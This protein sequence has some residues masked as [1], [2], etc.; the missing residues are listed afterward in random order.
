MDYAANHTEI[1]RRLVEER[2]DGYPYKDL[3]CNPSNHLVD[4]ME[5]KSP[6]KKKLR[7]K[8]ECYYLKFHCIS[9]LSF[10]T[11]VANVDDADV[12]AMVDFISSLHNL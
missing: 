1:A 9:L 3:E 5:G 11:N 8:G 10:W 4:H 12:E 6:K 7:Q 2:D